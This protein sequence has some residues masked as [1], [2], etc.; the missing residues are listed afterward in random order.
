MNQRFW[1]L[2]GNNY[3]ENCL[4]WKHSDKNPVLPSTKEKTGFKCN[5]TANP[6][7]L[8]FRGRRFLYYRGNGILANRPGEYHDRL[9]VAELFGTDGN[10]GLCYRE[11]NDGKMIVDVGKPG[12]FDCEHALDPAAVVFRDKVFLYYS[13]VGE[14]SNTIGLAISEDGEHFTKYGAVMPGRAPDVVV[15][16][17]KVY[18]ITHRKWENGKTQ[19]QLYLFVSEDGIHF[20]PVAPLEGFSKKGDWDSYALTTLRL[21]EEGDTYYLMYGGSA[22]LAD[23]PDFFGLAR[24]KDLIHWEAH[25]GNPIFGCSAKGMQDGG[26]IWFPALF[27]EKDQFVML[28]EGSRGKYTWDLDSQIC[29]ATI[30]K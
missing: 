6:D 26:A 24:S 19:S 14:T 17:G 13:G 30:S 16:D 3:V 28:Y 4:K 9:A 22:Y 29:L 12:E 23:E 15:R 5:W 27:E 2:F 1:N 7:I 25:P 11:L 21:S 20:T 8:E 18:L 10:G